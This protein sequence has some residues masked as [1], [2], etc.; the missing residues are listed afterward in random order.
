MKIKP[1]DAGDPCSATQACVVSLGEL[2]AGDT[3]HPSV[4][5]TFAG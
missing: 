5:I 1:S 4:E 2:V 3:P